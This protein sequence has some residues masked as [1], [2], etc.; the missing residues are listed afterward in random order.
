RYR[1][2][3]ASGLGTGVPWAKEID[4]QLH[5]ER[6]FRGT[7]RRRLHPMA[8]SSLPTGTFVSLPGAPGLVL[9]EAVVE[10]THDGYGTALRRPRSGQATVVTPPSSVAVLRA[11]YPVQIDPTALAAAARVG[12]AVARPGPR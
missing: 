1:A 4:R 2:D 6:L 5:A 3:W 9:P 8:W 11:G 10:W 12:S 7:H